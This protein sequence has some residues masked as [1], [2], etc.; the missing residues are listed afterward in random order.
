MTKIY[1]VSADHVSAKYQLTNVRFAV[2][3]HEESGRV[4]FRAA[5]HG[6]PDEYWASL[7]N[8]GCG[9]S[10]STAEKAIRDLLAAN[11]C[12][13]IRINEEQP[14]AFPLAA[15]EFPDFDLST[16]PA[17]PAEWRETSWH[18]D[19]CPSFMAY[20]QGETQI[21]VFVDYADTAKREHADGQRFVVCVDTEKGSE[22]EEGFDD[23]Q[24]V[25]D[26][27]AA[28]SAAPAS[29]GLKVKLAMEFGHEIQAA[30]S[31]AD[32]RAACDANKAEPVNSDV[33]HSHDYC[34]ANECMIAAF[35]AVE[36]RDSVAS[37]ARDAELIND[38]W[39]IAKAA[40]FFA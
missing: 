34:D 32:F 14:A 21:R 28:H 24:E 11:G 12:T 23:W 36:G 37:S 30:L 10:C 35:K 38:A 1:I 9:R 8:F 19:T 4:G 2:D 22:L 31:T 17:V 5:A 3:S 15:A 18:N 13:N 16:L 25:L 20:E 7:A 27:V 33:C 29:I 6:N 40:D 26:V 39:A